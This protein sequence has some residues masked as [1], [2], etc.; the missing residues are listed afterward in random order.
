ME[1]QPHPSHPASP[2][3]HPQPIGVALTDVC[4]FDR[5]LLGIII[6]IAYASLTC[7]IGI[8]GGPTLGDHEAINATAA[9]DAVENGRWLIPHPGDEPRV[10]KTPLGIWAIAATSVIVPKTEGRAVTEFTARLPSALA[11]LATVLIV[12]WLGAMSLGHR[13]G[14]VAGFI[15]ASCAGTL[16]FARNAQVEQLLTMFTSLSLACF[17]RGALHERP[18]RV[19]MALFY[20]AF[21]LA[22]MAKAPLPLVTVGLTLFVYWFVTLP[23]I[24]ASEHGPLPKAASRRW[25]E[26][27]GRRF[28]ALR[29]LWLLPGII[30]FVVVAGMWPVYVYLKVDN[31]LELWRIEYLDRFSGELSS[32]V[33]PFWYY[34]PLLFA[35]TFPFLASLPEGLASI[36]LPRYANHR[37]ALGY[38]FTWA[39][40]TLVFLSMS[41]FKRPHY[42]ASMIPALCLLLAPV[43]D[44][45]FF[46]TLHASA[47]VVRTVS[48]SLPLLIGGLWAAAVWYAQ[49]TYPEIAVPLAVG[50]AGTALCWV[51]ACLLFYGQC[52]RSALAMLL[53]GIPLLLA[54]SA[55]DAGKLISV[56]READALTKALIEHKITNDADIYWVDGRPNSAVEF[57]SGLRVQ[58]LLDLMEA[59]GVREGRQRASE[60]LQQSIGERL[61]QRLAE[62]KPAYFILSRDNYDLLSSVGTIP[63]KIAFEIKDANPDPADALVI[64]TQPDRPAAPEASQPQPPPPANP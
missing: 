19:F 35:L 11:A 15:T 45:L 52:R 12:Y 6:L 8:R 28:R 24:E 9:R 58:R 14:L 43:I 13:T 18:S 55:A 2:H 7:L 16:F 29:S 17:W 42:L 21:A 27:M 1:T 38:V 62:P 4:L 46:G 3:V 25:L 26:A 64:F 47:R 51:V 40:V 54:V 53:L 22:M 48:A 5:H 57:Y 34:L 56:N 31:A 37:R 39:A 23:L 10:R 20:V 61:A 36:F 32:K 41:A 30:V 59:A 33:P 50:L 60:G 49:R 63:H 44:R